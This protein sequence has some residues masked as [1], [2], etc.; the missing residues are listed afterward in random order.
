MNRDEEPTVELTKE[1]ATEP[2]E[3]SAAWAATRA[4]VRRLGKAE[5]DVAIARAERDARIRELA[6][7]GIPISVISRQLDL[8]RGWI[9]RIVSQGKTTETPGA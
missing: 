5:L 2:A 7:A 3:M 4:A 6:A 9:H 8:N 1:E